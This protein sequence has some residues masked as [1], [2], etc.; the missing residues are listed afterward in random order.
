MIAGM[1][2]NHLVD[3]LLLVL[4]LAWVIGGD[5]GGKPGADA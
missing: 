1:I 5:R 4:F 2:V 3:A